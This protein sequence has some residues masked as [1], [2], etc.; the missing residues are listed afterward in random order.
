MVFTGTFETSVDFCCDP[1]SAAKEFVV[2]G[3][4]STTTGNV[5]VLNGTL[6]LTMARPIRRSASSRFAGANSAFVVDT[7]PNNAFN[8]KSLVVGNGGKLNLASGVTIAGDGLT[9]NGVR[10]TPGTYTAANASTWIVGAG[11]RWW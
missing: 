11:S 2:S 7:A 5:E 1:A 6:R 3:K 4:T 9:L 10:M 8:V